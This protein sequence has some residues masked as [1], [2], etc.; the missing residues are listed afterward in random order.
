MANLTGDSWSGNF[1]VRGVRTKQT[2][3]VNQSGGVTP[4]TGSDWGPYTQTT[5][6]R[7][8]NDVLPSANIKFDVNKDLVRAAVARAISRPD[9]SAL[10]VRYR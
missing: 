4:I 3:I 5:F 1:G 2:S 6:E 9:Y 7:T 8:Y 10:A